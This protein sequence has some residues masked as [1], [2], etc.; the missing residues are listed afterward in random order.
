MGYPAPSFNSLERGAN[1]KYSNLTATGQAIYRRRN[2]LKRTERQLRR[3]YYEIRKTATPEESSA[4]YA[5]WKA[6]RDELKITP[7]YKNIADTYAKEKQG[8]SNASKGAAT[9]AEAMPVIIL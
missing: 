2:Y 1:M 4:A 3:E 9:A 8:E 7:Y 6:V 5:A